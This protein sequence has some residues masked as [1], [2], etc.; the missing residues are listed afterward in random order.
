MTDF[1]LLNRYSYLKS[2]LDDTNTFIGDA[3]LSL[4][5][6]DFS[7]LHSLYDLG[8]Y[9]R[10][11]GRGHDIIELQSS[12]GGSNSYGR[13]CGK[14]E[15]CAVVAALYCGLSSDKEMF[16]R[17][18]PINPLEE[19]GLFSGWYYGPFEKPR[20]CV[21]SL[22]ERRVALRLARARGWNYRFHKTRPQ[23]T[24]CSDAGKNVVLLGNSPKPQS[25]R[26]DLEA[27][28]RTTSV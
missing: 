9:A 25:T 5:H 28:A 26:P 21:D 8:I 3:E 19:L 1:T 23:F 16:H 11:L 13:H 17:M 2:L 6:T 20:S 12:C 24:A 15:K 4:V 10:F 22:S 18:F 27:S 14:C 7:P